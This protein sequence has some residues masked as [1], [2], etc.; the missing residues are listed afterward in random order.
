MTLYARIT[1]DG[2]IAEYPYDLRTLRRTVSL[3]RD[4]SI[5]LLACHGIVPV[6]R[7]QQPCVDH[8]QTITEAEPKKV[9]GK[10]QQSWSVKAATKREV[11]DRT[12]AQAERI[13]AER[14]ERMAREVDAIATH[15]LRW[16]ELTTEQ[17]DKI[18]A[19]RKALRDVSQ[20]PG[21]PW[22]VE[23]PTLD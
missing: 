8:T 16:D 14:D 12:A 15:P 6:E 23:W 1:T 10:W 3:P 13:R 7:S 5:E 21:F 17:R 9:K 11:A 2:A 18:A 20:Q 22:A 19:H 4:P